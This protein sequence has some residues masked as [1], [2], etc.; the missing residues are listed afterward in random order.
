M[1]DY[2]ANEDIYNLFVKKRIPE[3]ERFLWI[4]TADLKDLHI[5]FGGRVLPFLDLLAR[6][7]KKGVEIRMI[8]AKEPGPRFR[9]DFD[10]HPELIDPERFERV[11]CPRSHFKTIIVDGKIAFTGSA[12]LTGVGIGMRSPAKRN[13]ETGIITDDPRLIEAMMDHFDAIFL[14]DHCESCG[15]REVCP[16]PIR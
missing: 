6:L 12:N 9:E 1:I 5:E 3:A 13:F 2:L 11:L 14:G 8:H 10:R 4:A 16:D 7:I 15:L